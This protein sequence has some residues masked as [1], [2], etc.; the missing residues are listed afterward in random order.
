MG[1]LALRSAASTRSQGELVSCSQLFSH[2]SENWD[3][4]LFADVLF[5][6]FFFLF[7]LFRTTLRQHSAVCPQV[8]GD[9]VNLAARLM[10]AAKPGEVLVDEATMDATETQIFYEVCESE[11]RCAGG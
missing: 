9:M 10:A 5:F 11:R 3:N 1:S 8:I 6:L 2:T 4:S 7:P